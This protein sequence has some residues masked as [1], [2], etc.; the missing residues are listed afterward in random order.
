M[1]E[2]VIEPE[3]TKISWGPQHPMSGQ[4][5][6]ILDVDGERVHR[7]TAD[8]G[9]THRGVEKTLENRSFFQGIIPIERM[10]MVDTANIGIGYVM[11]IEEA[12]GVEV[13]ERANWIRSLVCEM[14]RINSHLYAFGLQAEATGYFPAVFLWTTVDRG[15]LLDLFEELT[16]ARWSYN[17]FVPGGV[18]KDLP[19]GFKTKVLEAVR[20]LRRRF[21]D[22]WKAMIDNKLFEMRCNN[23]GN[24][25][26]EDAIRLGATGPVL[27]G[28]GIDIDVRR[29]DPYAAYADLDF[30][31]VTESACDSMARTKVRLREADQSLNMMEQIAKEI[32]EGKVKELTSFFSRAP[33]G[34]VISRV[35]TARGEL[36]IHMFTDGG[37]NPYRV[38]INSPTLRN[39]YVYERLAEL[40][41]VVMADIPVILYSID[42]WYLDSDR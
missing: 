39:M 27:R 19:E 7:I 3:T 34:E 20:Y 28:S 18:N 14:G 5:R 36:G 13:P 33:A 24:L 31:V 37:S 29:D 26:R 6:I 1:T 17:F 30:Q 23:V 25:S 8:L 38:K 35:E 21:E 11:A 15:V 41:E 2:P 22:Y 16:G 10:A 32:P 40:D 42:P 9:F 12:L 4:T